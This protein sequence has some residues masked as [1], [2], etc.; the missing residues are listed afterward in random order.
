L[1]GNRIRI[2]EFFEGFVNITRYKTFFD[3]FDLY[4]WK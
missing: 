2:R 4:I 1:E 3:N